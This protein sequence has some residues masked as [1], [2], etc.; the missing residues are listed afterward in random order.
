MK[1]TS[2][3]AAGALVLAAAL[4]SSGCFS[5]AGE[6]IPGS[7]PSSGTPPGVLGSLSVSSP[8]LGTATVAPTE[9]SSG[10]RQQFLGGDFA[11]PASGLVV[12]L[13]VDPLLGPGARVFAVSDPFGKSVVLRRSECATFR[14][15]LE[16][17]GWRVNDV[18]DYRLSLELDCALADGTTVHGSVSTTHCH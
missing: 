14:F 8:L 9:C 13:A 5:L 10:D 18:R 2:A 15:S 11:D 3:A 16:E 1:R 6:A 7:T 12:R 17:T 4:V